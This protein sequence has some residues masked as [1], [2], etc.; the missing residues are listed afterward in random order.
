MFRTTGNWNSVEAETQVDVV[1]AFEAEVENIAGGA[2]RNALQGARE[3]AFIG[4]GNHKPKIDA[5]LALIVVIDETLLRDKR[6][7][8]FKLAGWAGESGK[9]AGARRVRAHHGADAADNSQLLQA[10]QSSEDI[11][12]VAVTEAG[13]FGKWPAQQWESTLPLVG[14]FNSGIKRRRNHSPIRLARAVK[15]MPLGLRAG[16]SANFDR[17]AVS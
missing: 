4:G 9:G 8:L 12:L 5:V 15:K 2:P 14:Q 6:R 1:G 16:S 10:L 17:V 13:D 3:F 7:N 11:S